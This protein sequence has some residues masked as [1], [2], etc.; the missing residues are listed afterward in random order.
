MG[1]GGVDRVGEPLEGLMELWGLSF[2]PPRCTGL[3]LAPLFPGLRLPQ[4][5][6]SWGEEREGPG[7]EGG[8]KG[9]RGKEKKPGRGRKSYA[10]ILRVRMR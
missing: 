2:P 5:R 9:A 6:L 7:E 3:E 8:R 4:G 10:A 1:V